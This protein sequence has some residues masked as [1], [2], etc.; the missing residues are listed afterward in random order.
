MHELDVCGL[1]A[2]TPALIPH[3]THTRASLGD[4]VMAK[5]LIVDDSAF[6]RNVVEMLV[7]QGGH[8]V[9]GRA[10]NSEAA[11]E[12]FKRLH[13]ELVT[14]DYLMTDKS[15]EE[16]LQEIIELDPSARVIMV[17]GS[18]DHTIGEK[19]LQHGAKD[20]V[21]K[22]FMKRDLLKVIDQVMAA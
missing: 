16:V 20:F 2:I 5:I 22:P 10:E 21:E 13:P 19:A 9:V 6:A 1:I 3:C 15:G 14:L 12:L 7:E 17:S 4:R 11:L 8:E 18:G